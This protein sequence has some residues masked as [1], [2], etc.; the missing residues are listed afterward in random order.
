MTRSVQ[1][2][3]LHVLDERRETAARQD[4]ELEGVARADA[5]DGFEQEINAFHRAKIRGV[6]DHHLV[7][8]HAKFAAHF[9]A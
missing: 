6:E 8:R 3:P 7:V 9:L 2:Q 4:H 1:A 5:R